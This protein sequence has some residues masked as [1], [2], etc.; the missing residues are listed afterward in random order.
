MHHTIGLGERLLILLIAI[1]ITILN[2]TDLLLYFFKKPPNTVYIG[3]THWYEDFFYYLSQFAQGARGRW[4]VE[5]Q[6]TTEDIPANINWIL[7]LMLGKIGA[8]LALPPW[9]SYH[10][11]LIMFSLLYVF[12]LY[13]ASHRI[14]PKHAGYRLATFIFTL[15]SGGFFL[16]SLTKQSILIQ[17]YTYFYAYTSPLHRLGGV[18]HLLIQNILSLTAVLL[19]CSF[20]DVVFSGHKT[21]GRTLRQA[22][23]MIFTLGTL[24]VINPVYVAMDV[25]VFFLTGIYFYFRRKSIVFL[26][27]LLL[28]LGMISLILVPLVSY[29]WQVFSHP[30]YQYFR[31]WEAA[32]PPTDIKTFFLSSG[33]V[34][35]L[36]PIGMHRFISDRSPLRIT[37]SLY[38]FL[39]IVLYF[40]PIPVNLSIPYFRLLQ[41]PAYLFLVAMAIEGL[42]VIAQLTSTRMKRFNSAVWFS[43]L[44]TSVLLIQIPPL[45]A[46]V[47]EKTSAYYLSSYLNFVPNELWNGLTRLRSVARGEHMLAT[48]TLELLAPTASGLHVYSAHRSLTLDYERKIANIQQFYDGKM[49]PSDAY[50]FLQDNRLR[51]ILWQKQ[52][53]NVKELLSTYLFLRVWYKNDSLAIL[54]WE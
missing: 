51:Y 20:I 26:K 43:L 14:F 24:F 3:I 41:P 32:V 12:L 2:L 28:Y 45:V 25:S 27:H 52:L 31:Q 10:I 49:N 39:P 30:F 36:A 13:C 29:Q 48:G 9:S 22:V 17:P 35:V 5:N 40:S 18:P 50:T 44:F 7:N 33:I 53:G 46:E 54:T 4:L 21:Y 15:T 6:F 37:G 47:R 34:S 38:A 16:F 23:I 11:S 42:R 8:L 1:G 19:W